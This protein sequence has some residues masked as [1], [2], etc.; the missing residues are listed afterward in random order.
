MNDPSAGSPTDAVLRLLHPL[1][2]K[3]HDTSLRRT[4]L[5]AETQVV[6]VIC[7]NIQSVE[8]TGGVYKGQGRNQHKVMT[9]PY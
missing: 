3:A 8:A 1:D 2:D 6:H 9:C 5:D 4:T 7:R